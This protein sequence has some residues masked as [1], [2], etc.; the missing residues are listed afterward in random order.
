MSHETD[1]NIS[2]AHNDWQFAVNKSKIA[3]TN[4][5]FSTAGQTNLA[6]K[7]AKLNHEVN[8]YKAK[9]SKH[10]WHMSANN[11]KIDTH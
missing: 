5:Q 1:F 10:N 11:T 4:I 2:Y 6:I 3:A 9:T 7:A 8:D